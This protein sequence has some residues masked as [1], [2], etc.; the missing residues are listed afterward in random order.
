ME[1]KVVRVIRYLTSLPDNLTVNGHLSC[2]DNQLA[3]LPDNLKVAGDLSC[4]NNHL[5]SLPDNLTVG[6]D[7]VCFNNS[8]KLPANIY[9][10]SV[11]Q[12]YLSKLKKKIF[13]IFLIRVDKNAN[14]F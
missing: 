12:F 14:L 4:G 6:G 7:L 13:T 3:S 5:T 8:S 11:T 10:F 1:N 9:F 2:R